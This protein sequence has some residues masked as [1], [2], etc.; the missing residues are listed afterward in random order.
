VTP[1]TTPPTATSSI[2]RP[3]PL[4]IADSKGR[5]PITDAVK[6]LI[7]EALAGIPEGKSRALLVIADQHGSRAMWAQKLGTNWR[8]TAQGQTSWTG[9]ISGQVAILGSW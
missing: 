9:Q 6:S 5:F 8:V 4:T 2:L 1:N 3:T 7:G